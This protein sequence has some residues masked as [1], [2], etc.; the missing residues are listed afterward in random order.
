MG[1]LALKSLPDYVAD[2]LLRLA[3]FLRLQEVNQNHLLIHGEEIAALAGLDI[4]VPDQRPL[5]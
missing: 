5:P 2:H 4:P 1:S 3:E